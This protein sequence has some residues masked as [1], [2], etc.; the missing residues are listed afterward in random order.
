[1]TKTNTWNLTEGLRHYA[2]EIEVLQAD[3]QARLLRE[4]RDAT[5][6]S[7][8]LE[9]HAL[10]SVTRTRLMAQVRLGERAKKRLICSNV[11]L[12]IWVARRAQVRCRDLELDDLVQEG[13]SGLSRAIEKYDASFGTTLSTYATWWIRQSI[14]RAIMNG[15]LVRIPVH[16]QDGTFC[17]SQVRSSAKRFA[18]IDSLDAVLARFDTSPDDGE[19]ELCNRPD[20]DLA[21]LRDPASEDDRDGIEAR[22]TVET[23]LG[24]LSE[25]EAMILRMRNGIDG[26]PMTLEEIGRSLGITR[27]R[28]RQI[29]HAA[30]E[31]GRKILAK[32]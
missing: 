32:A 19:G 12:V 10:D 9:S 5:N 11:R 24:Q 22:S 20:A 27:E 13:V 29:E 28:V 21:A 31:K 25:R 17:S 14:D 3:V 6:A 15:G 2:D 26:D 23:V 18:R 8:L 16:V 7:H 30:L 1:M 4:V